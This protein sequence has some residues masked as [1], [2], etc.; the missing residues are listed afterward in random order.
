MLIWRVVI[1]IL[2]LETVL[3]FD[4]TL[5]LRLSQLDQLEGFFILLTHVVAVL[6]AVQVEL[7]ME[8]LFVLWIVVEAH[9][10]HS[11]VQLERER[12]HAIVD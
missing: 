10:W 9:N 3:L 6:Q 7:Q 1:F 5:E 8:H 12:V 11:I 2:L 4:Y